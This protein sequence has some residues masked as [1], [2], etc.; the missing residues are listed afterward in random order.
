MSGRGFGILAY[1]CYLPRARLPQSLVADAHRWLHSSPKTA[2][3][4]HRSFCNWDEDALTMGVE[5]ARSCLADADRSSINRVDLASTSLPFADRSNVGV[6]R[7]ALEIPESASLADSGGSLRAASTALSRALRGS[8]DETVLVVGS[9]C[10]D[11]KPA[12]PDEA[13]TGHAAAAVLVGQG[14]PCATLLG[15]ASLHQDF[16]DHYRASGERFD[17]ALEL[18]WARDAGYRDQVSDVYKQALEDAG[19]GTG[20][21][22]RL[23]IAAPAAM[24]GAIARS[25][26]HEDAGADVR[27]RV[28][29]CG[30]AQPLLLLNGLLENARPRE[31]LALISIGQGVDVLVFEACGAAAAN[32]LAAQIG[33]GVDETNYCRYLTLRRLLDVEEGKR[34]ERDNRTSQSAFWRKH[35]VVTG[36]KGG[37]CSACG[38]LQ[39]PPSRVCVSCG[40]RGTQSLRRLADM[41][42]RVRSFTEDWLAYTQRPPLI[43]GN[44]GFENGANVMMEF[45]DVDPGQLEVGMAVEMRFRIKDFDE[46][47]GFRRYFWKPSPG[48][49]NVRG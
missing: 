8:R 24:A 29:Y 40:A 14:D 33:R 47:R 28:G 30:T 23:A 19:A 44:V 48:L 21:I 11:T 9:D 36:F 45:T 43:F 49:E 10:V 41:T 6:L 22:D 38:T 4:Q 35:D 17:Y 34:A 7:E 15:S 37:Q 3:E 42:G 46:R 26:K 13:T 1:G 27:A 31:K 39:F 2:R 25:L 16:V 32:R 20:E 5:A 12:S 18:R